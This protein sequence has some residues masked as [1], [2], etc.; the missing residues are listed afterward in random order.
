MLAREQNLDLLPSSVDV[1]VPLILVVAQRR[2]VPDAIAEHAH[3]I[4][5]AERIEQRLGTAGQRPLPGL[6]RLDLR[7]QLP[8][9]PL[10]L[11]PASADVTEVPRVLAGI[12]SLSGNWPGLGR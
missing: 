11:V 9:A 3:A 1:V 6:E 7:V 5:R 12:A 4:H 8:I 10:P 2:V